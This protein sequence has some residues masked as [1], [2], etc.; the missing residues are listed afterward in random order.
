MPV[1]AVFEGVT[2]EQYEQVVSRITDGKTR[3]ES[4][5]DWPVAGVLA[6]AAG[7]GANGFRVI[8]VW[9]SEDAFNSF[10]ETLIPILQELSVDVEP[11][12]YEA[13]AFLTA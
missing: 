8:D 13:L 12:V 9:E 7:Q 11:E 10:G 4:P 5:S 2:Q 6:H 3:M 1:V